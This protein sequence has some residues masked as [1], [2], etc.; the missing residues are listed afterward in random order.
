MNDLWVPIQFIY[1]VHQRPRY[2][3]ISLM[4]MNLCNKAIFLKSLGMFFFSNPV[5]HAT[6]F[7]SVCL[8]PANISSLPPLSC[9]KVLPIC[10]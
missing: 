3:W 1:L 2:L 8:F 7:I 9:K 5:L 4:K 6:F 10:Y